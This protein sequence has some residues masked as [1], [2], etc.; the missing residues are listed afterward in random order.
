MSKDGFYIVEG[1][2]TYYSKEGNPITIN[3]VADQNG[4]QA[5]GDSIPQPDQAIVKAV[6]YL[7]SLP[8]PKE[9]SAPASA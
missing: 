6:E 8:P 1:S 7:R 9:A 2:Y 4:Y 3:Y 5:S